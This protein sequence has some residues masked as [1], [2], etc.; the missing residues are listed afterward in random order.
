MLDS[1]ECWLQDTCKKFKRDSSCS[2]N[3]TFC[4]KQFKLDKLYDLC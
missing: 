1:R 4:I 2:T 3:D